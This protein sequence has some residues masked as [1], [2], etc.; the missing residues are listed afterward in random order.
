MFAS[1]AT[2]MEPGGDVVFRTPRK[3]AHHDQTGA[4]RSAS[5][6]WNGRAASKPDAELLSIFVVGISNGRVQVHEMRSSARRTAY[7]WIA[8]ALDPRGDLP[9][10]IAAALEELGVNPLAEPAPL[11]DEL[12]VNGVLYR[13]VPD[14]I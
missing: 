10:H 6:F 3:E 14:A 8:Y 2:F 13:R 9:P 5:R 12:V 4:R 7:P 11:P 1:V